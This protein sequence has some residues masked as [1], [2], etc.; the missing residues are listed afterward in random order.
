MTDEE[1]VV[2][3]QAEGDPEDK[4]KLE[5]WERNAYTI[6][7]VIKSLGSYIELE[8][9][10]QESWFGF[11]KAIK[12]YSPEKAPVFRVH[13]AVNVR[14]HVLSYVWQHETNN[15]QFSERRLNQYRH[16]IETYKLEHGEKPT[17][18]DIMG[19][20]NITP[21]Q[22]KNIKRAEQNR[23]TISCDKKITADDGEDYYS[24]LVA[25]NDTESEAVESVFN[26]ERRK[27][28]L[29][30]VNSL[31]KRQREAVLLVHYAGM[32]CGQIAE[33]FGLS[34]NSTKSYLLK[35]QRNIK[36]R[37]GQELSQFVDMRATYSK[38]VQGTG[39][40]TFRRTGTSATERTALWEIEKET[41]N[42]QYLSDLY[43]GQ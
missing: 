17:D 7:K 40:G 1:I 6:R 11:D 9:L 33:Q 30:A 8:D 5:L 25:A 34:R 38:G 35:G 26:Q 37:Y 23:R 3:I 24:F 29:K 16:F 19:G 4:L 18:A 43:G 21:Y 13:L 31:K 14:T 2:K 10:L 28:V 27:A 41:E 32:T 20:L 12:T 15:T 42:R 36:K 22:L 39:T